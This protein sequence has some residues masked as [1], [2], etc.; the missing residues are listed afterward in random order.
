MTNNLPIVDVEALQQVL[1]AYIGSINQL[2]FHS[3]QL[4][5]WG[6]PRGVHRNQEFIEKMRRTTMLMNTLASAGHRPLDRKAT[7]LCIGT[8]AASVLESDIELTSRVIE[9]TARA[10]DSA[11]ST[12]IK[13]LLADLAQSECADL[14]CLQT[15]ATGAEATEPNRHQKFLMPKPGGERTAIQ[16]INQALPAMTAAVSEIFLHSLLFKS[17]NR[18][19]LADREL[20]AAVSM[21]FRSEALLERLLDLGGLPT[22]QGHGAL[23]IGAHQ[24]A[25]DDISKETL[26]CIA[27]QLTDALTTVD[28]YSD[29]TTHTLM[30]GVLSSITAEA[31]IRPPST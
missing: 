10:H 2:F 8:D 27:Q 25:I 17:W 26:E 29:P 20:D 9:V 3:R 11:E 14:E 5:A 16:A 15:W 31:A 13:T 24:A 28:G 1:D 21:M 22:G 19:T 30:D 23:R 7:A 12:E 6:H 4:R 18:Q